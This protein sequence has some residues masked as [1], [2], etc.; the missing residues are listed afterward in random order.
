MTI[1]EICQLHE[2][3]EVFYHVDGYTARLLTKDG[4]KIVASGTGESIRDALDAL[5]ANVSK[6]ADV[7]SMRE[8][9]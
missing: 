2:M 7:R 1:D 3:I 9:L 8:G 6:F 4:D 5:E